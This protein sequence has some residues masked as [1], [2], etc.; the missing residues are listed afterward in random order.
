MAF[1]KT[2]SYSEHSYKYSFI[3]TQIDYCKLIANVHS[4]SSMGMNFHMTDMH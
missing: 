1:V 2:N 4:I 3:D